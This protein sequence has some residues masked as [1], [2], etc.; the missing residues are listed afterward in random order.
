MP[1]NFINSFVDIGIG[2]R[3]FIYFMIFNIISW[4]CIVGPPMVLFARYLDMKASLVGGLIALPLSSTVLILFTVSLVMR[5]GPKRLMLVTW[6]FRNFFTCII[7]LVPMV[8]S[9]DNSQ[10]ASIV[11]F[12]A[13]ASYCIIRSAGVG[14]WLP[15]LHEIIPVE[16]RDA[17]FSMETSVAQMTNVAISLGQAF[18][19]GQDPTMSNF[20][21]VYAIGIIAGMFS[22]YFMSRVPGGAGVEE[23]M[24]FKD[25]LKTYPIVLRD[26]P[27]MAFNISESLCWCALSFYWSSNIMYM[28]DL[29][30][31]SERDI[32]FIAGVGSFLVFLTVRAWGRFAQYS[33]R[34]EA[35]F[36][37]MLAQSVFV[38]ACIFIPSDSPHAIWYAGI[39]YVFAALFGVAH[40]TLSHGAALSFVQEEAK[41]GY[42]NIWSLTSSLALGL[43][44]V[45]VGFIIDYAGMEWGF[46]I[47]FILSATLGIISSYITWNIVEEAPRPEL[48][49]LMDVTV[50]MRTAARIIWVTMGRHTDTRPKT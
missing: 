30:Q 14:G 22:L 44:A 27:F 29:L 47:C 35:L 41:V 8:F 39:T 21:L 20:I 16:K 5:F 4:Q 11:F 17:Y 28:R 46:R 18:M 43:T 45:L 9:K 49:K 33:G 24:S 42:T 3:R 40:W 6:L 38:A 34:G 32:M 48:G 19:L 15:W 36:L 37:T 26:K 7:F 50:P 2:G 1:R 31:L 23:R 10:L 13:I 25:S 12:I